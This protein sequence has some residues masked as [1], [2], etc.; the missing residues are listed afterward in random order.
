MVTEHVPVRILDRDRT[1]DQRAQALCEIVQRDALG[2]RARQRPVDLLGTLDGA[3]LCG[4]QF[5]MEFL[6]DPGEGYVPGD[7]EQRQ[8]EAVGVF[9]RVV[10]EA[11]EVGRHREPDP[12]ELASGERLELRALRPR[13]ERPCEPGRQQQL[14]RP[15]PRRGIRQI[16]HVRP[17]DVAR[18][19][20]R[21]GDD[22]GAR[23][24]GEQE[25][26]AELHALRLDRKHDKSAGSWQVG[27]LPGLGGR[28]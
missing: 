4:E 18:E 5:A 19:A 28:V 22:R 9:A 7:L 17:P 2:C 27:T 6:R 25:R 10:G 14:V 15:D 24:A 26:V 13:I 21:A 3:L 8:P 16:D 11:L 20:A 1:A 23:E 12:G